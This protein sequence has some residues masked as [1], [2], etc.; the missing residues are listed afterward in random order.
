MDSLLCGQECEHTVSNSVV[1]TFNKGGTFSVLPYKVRSSLAKL[2]LRRQVYSTVHV[3]ALSNGVRLLS[4]SLREGSGIRQCVGLA[5]QS[6]QLG[7]RE[8]IAISPNLTNLTGKFDLRQ[9]VVTNAQISTAV[10]RKACQVNGLQLVTAQI[11]RVLL[12]GVGT[13]NYTLQ[14]VVQSR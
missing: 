4:L 5:L 2:G 11:Q 9:L 13:E 12:V 3:D 7:K 10:G 8:G 14:T 6:I 1:C